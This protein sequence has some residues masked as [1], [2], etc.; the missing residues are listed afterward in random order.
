MRLIRGNTKIGRGGSRPTC[1][2]TEIGRASQLIATLGRRKDLDVICPYCGYDKDC[3]LFTDEHVLPRA[4]GGNVQPTNPFRCRVCK[5]CNS[6]CGR[7]I[8]GRFAKSWPIHNWKTDAARRTYDPNAEVAFP[9]SYIGTRSDWNQADGTICEFWLGPTGDHIYHFHEPYTDADVFAG[10]PP[11]IPA[12]KVDPGTVFVAFV[13]TN[14]VWPPIVYRGARETFDEVTPIHLVNAAPHRDSVPYPALTTSRQQAQ[15]NWIKSRPEGVMV[16]AQLAMDV[17]WGERFLIK[18]GIGLGA[19]L[20]GGNFVTS[21][22]SGVLRKALW[23][24]KPESRA[25]LGIRG[26]AFLARDEMQMPMF[27]IPQCHTIVV[28]PVQG[29]LMALLNLYGRHEGMIQISDDQQLWECLIPEE[30]RTWTIAPAFRRF[31]GPVSII[32]F[33][34]NG[35]PETSPLRKQI[36]AILDSGVPLPPYHLTDPTEPK[37]A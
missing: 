20:L 26:S 33:M 3:A 36:D 31:V 17:D 1:W 12:T 8:D 14:P 11:H 7:W 19:T 6:A 28:M 4:L 25:Q 13:G 18:F 5:D 22:H 10:R 16:P 29:R 27:A 9:P 15:Y 30:G 23:E 34:N 21:Q 24:R 32:D 2:T 35:E 37:S